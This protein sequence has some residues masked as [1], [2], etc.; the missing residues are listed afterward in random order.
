[1]GS[2]EVEHCWQS[3]HACETDG[4]QTDVEA[5]DRRRFQHT[6]QWFSGMITR[7][8]ESPAGPQRHTSSCNLPALHAATDLSSER[9]H[10]LCTKP[11]P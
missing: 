9:L 1:M 4:A 8:G 11:L 10:T 6:A 7:T 3:V 2:P 5:P